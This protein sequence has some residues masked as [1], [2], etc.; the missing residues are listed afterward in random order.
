MKDLEIKIDNDNITDQENEDYI[1]LTEYLFENS[2][3]TYEAESKKI[4][5]GLGFI[6]IEENVSVLS[7]GWRM[8]LALGKALLRKPEILILDEPTNH[9]DLG[10]VVWLTDY[11]L[12]YKKTLIII[13]HQINLVNTISDVI[14]YI[15]NLDLKGNK[16]YTINGKYYNL[17][18][19]IEQQEKEVNNNWEKYQKKLEELRKKSTPKKDIEEFVKK[20]N[21]SRPNRPYLVK[22]IFDEVIRLSTKI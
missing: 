11:L 10:A 15:G 22:I 17:L 13:T 4:L 7:G 14:W 18:K 8:R 21:V 2:W 3:D 5:N 19:F 1:Q 9:L 12:N 6:K 20:N 16:V